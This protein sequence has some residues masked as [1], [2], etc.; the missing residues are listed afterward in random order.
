MG[1]KWNKGVIKLQSREKTF[2]SL[3]MYA[4][5]YIEAQL[6][7]IPSENGATQYPVL[8]MF[9]VNSLSYYYWNVS[10]GLVAVYYFSYL[11]LFSL[12]VTCHMSM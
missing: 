7:D 2:G 6:H 4:V 5:F 10:V 9:R 3:A 12:H 1:E 8:Q 11:T